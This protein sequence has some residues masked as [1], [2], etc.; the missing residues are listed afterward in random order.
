MLV[1]FANQSAFQDI[2]SSMRT[3]A[4]PILDAQGE[5]RPGCA[6]RPAMDLHQQRRL[7]ARRQLIV[8]TTDKPHT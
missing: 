6:G 3:A 8:L 5:G 1:L 7:L 4:G 2:P